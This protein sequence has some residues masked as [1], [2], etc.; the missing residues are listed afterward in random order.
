MLRN[1]FFVFA[2][3]SLLAL[4]HTGLAEEKG[5]GK[6]TH[7]S[8][9]GRPVDDSLRVDTEKKEGKDGQFFFRSK[10]FTKLGEA[11]TDPS[12]RIWGDAVRDE[13]GKLVRMTQ[14]DAISYCK[15]IGARL[16]SKQNWENLYRYTGARYVLPD[17]GDGFWT[18]TI[19]RRP[20]LGLGSPLGYAAFGGGSTVNSYSSN[21]TMG[22]RC[23]MP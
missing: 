9:S 15:G 14:D 5:K 10:N 23:V 1:G 18:S 19:V 11:W 8:N 6:E 21:T 17:Q 4:N 2:F 20:I 7:A 12:G 13:K 22:V 3:F 16:P